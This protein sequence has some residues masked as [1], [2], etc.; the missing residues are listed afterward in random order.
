MTNA[1]AYESMRA[2]QFYKMPDQHLIELQ[3]EARSKL[4]AFN[5]TPM[6]EME[7]RRAMLKEMLGTAGMGTIVSPVTWEYGRHIHLGERYFINF[8]CV[9]LDG[10]DVC[11]LP[12]STVRESIGYAQQDAFLFSTTVTR[13]VGYALRRR[14]RRQAE[15]DV[16]VVDL[17]ELVGLGGY[18]DRMPRTLSGGERQRVALARSLAA[19]PRLVLLD[20]PLSA[21]DAELRGRLASDLRRILREA[22]TTALFVTHDQVEAY[23]VADRVAVMRAGRVVQ[24]GTT[25]E[26]WSHP[27]DADVARFLGDTRVLDGALAASLLAAAGW[28]APPGSRVLLQVYED[29]LA[30]LPP[31]G[32]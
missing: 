14:G 3:V 12:L 18:G 22:G 5:A 24:Q 9:F 10:A 1:S 13:N 2:G 16:R 23:A 29:R 31:A 30:V 7:R 19:D 11:D 6:A 26:V 27:V 28:S 15:I 25:E 20:E 21:L 4:D 8:D 32:I 17:L